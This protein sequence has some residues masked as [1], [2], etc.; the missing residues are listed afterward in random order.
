MMDREPLG[1][2]NQKIELREGIK[3]ESL[4]L[5]YITKMNKYMHNYPNVSSLK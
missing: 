1:K 5:C 2:E 3:T 4:S